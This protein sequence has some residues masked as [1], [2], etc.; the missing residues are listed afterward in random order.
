MVFCLLTLHLWVRLFGK[1][2][3]IKDLAYADDCNVIKGPTADHVFELTKH[4]LHT[5]PDLAD[6]AHH[7]TR[8]MFTTED[9]EVLGSPVGIDRFI[10]TFVAQNC[11]KIMEDTERCA[12]QQG[13]LL[14][15]TNF[16]KDERSP[17]L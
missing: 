2:P 13:L 6:I 12:K 17:P 14:I 16:Q 1:F 8:D 3:E 9:I 15:S 7:F 11:V 5:D 10:K 4:F